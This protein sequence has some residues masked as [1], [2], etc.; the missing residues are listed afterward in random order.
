[1]DF[2]DQ[3]HRMSE[4]TSKLTQNVEEASKKASARARIRRMMS[5]C[6]SDLAEVYQE[7][8]LKYYAEN[9]RDPDQS[10][11]GLFEQVTDLWMQMDTLKAELAGLDHATICPSCGAKVDDLQKFCPE[12]GCK[13]VSYGKWQ[14]EQRTASA[15][16]KDAESTIQGTEKSVYKTT[17]EDVCDD[18]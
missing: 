7:I 3:F 17:V 9:Q 12:C 13:N 2:R 18:D 16:T 14:S 11:V 1:M 4:T 6:K 5:R 10:Y 8:G 15:D